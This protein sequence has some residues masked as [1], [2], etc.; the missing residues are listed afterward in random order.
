M[1][2]LV[3]T[4]ILMCSFSVTAASVS[5]QAQTPAGTPDEHD[6]VRVLAD[7]VATL[8]WVVYSARSEQG[9]WEIQCCRPNGADIRNLT[10]TPTSNEFSP[11]VSRD[12]RRLLYRRLPR[13]AAIDNNRHG[14]QGELVL[15]DSDGSHPQTLGAA[16]A[17]PWASWSP[18]GQ[19]IAC[20]S[21]KGIFFVDVA[22]Q[23]E[24]RRV[25]RKGFFQQ[26]TWS[27][28][29]QW[30]SGV[31]NSFGASW[32]V[33]RMNVT[34][35]EANALHKVDCCTPDWFPDSQQVIF[36]WRPPGQKSNPGYGW[37]QL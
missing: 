32:S 8:G 29:G 23:K 24:V 34:S 14:A 35:G 9:D 31:A 25:P 13:S 18:D 17:Y 28:D 26:L 5:G 10:R 21:I 30:L 3:V 22:T 33:A 4:L 36:S 7:E 27:P 37:T 12:G 2:R 6:A 11:Q 19:Q 15:A 1:N 16:E 20:L